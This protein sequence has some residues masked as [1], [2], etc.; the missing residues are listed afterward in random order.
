MLGIINSCSWAS[1]V[2]VAEEAEDSAAVTHK[3][4]MVARENAAT[5]LIDA[6]LYV[7]RGRHHGDQL[8]RSTFSFD[9]AGS[10]FATRAN[11]G[12]LPKCH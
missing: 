1:V 5:S 8:P 9:D 11:Y 4:D 6:G 7:P 2:A 3:G 10:A 12:R